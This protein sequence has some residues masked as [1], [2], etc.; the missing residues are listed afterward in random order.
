LQ[1]FKCLFENLTVLKTNSNMSEN[2]DSHC[3]C[4]HG[5]SLNERD[6][7]ISDKIKEI[8]CALIYVTDANPQ[9]AYTIGLTETFNHPE[10][11]ICGDLG[12]QCLNSVIGQSLQKLEK[13]KNAF[14]IVEGDVYS[15]EH[16]ISNKMFEKNVKLSRDIPESIKIKDGDGFV[17]APLGCTRVCRK[18]KKEMMYQAYVRYGKKFS[19]LQLLVPDMHGKLPWHQ[20]FDQVWAKAANQ[21]DLSNDNYAAPVKEDFICKK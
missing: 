5:Q 7:I 4:C 12:A 11:I 3:A 20:D 21:T 16:E 10:F 19:A 13:D 17:L 9:F 14:M 18:Y 6:R 15:A 8:G 2:H 1:N